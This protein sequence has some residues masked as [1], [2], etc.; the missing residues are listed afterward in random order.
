MAGDTPRSRKTRSTTRS[1]GQ[2]AK[3][4]KVSA[5][6]SRKTAVHAKAATTTPPA[7]TTAKAKTTLFL[8]RLAWHESRSPK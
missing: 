2:G 4:S 1:A 7:S 3:S 8:P 5:T 6:S